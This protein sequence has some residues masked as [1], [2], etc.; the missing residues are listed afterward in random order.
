MSIKIF[1]MTHKQFEAPTDSMY[2]PLQVGHAISPELGYLA[3]DTGD[4]ISR[5]NKSFCELTGIYWL[6]KNYHAC[7]YIGICHYRRYLI[8]RQGLIFTEK[9]LMRL[10]QNHDM[11]TPKLLTLNT[12]Y[13]NGFSQNH[14]QKDLLI[15]E[16]VISEKYPD[17]VPVFHHMVHDVHTYF[18]NIFIFLSSCNA[19]IS[20]FVLFGLIERRHANNV[21]DKF[22]IQLFYAY[23]EWLFDI[24]FEVEC[25][26]DI[27]SYDNYC[28]RLFGFLSEFLLTVYIAK[29]NLSTYECMVGMSG[30][31]HETRMLRESL[32]KCFADG[33]YQKAQSIF[34]ESYAKRP[35]ILMEASDITGELHLCMQ[36]ISTCSFEQELYGHNLL[37]MIHDYHSLMEFCH[38]LNEIVNHFLTVTESAADISWLKKSTALSPKA[39]DIAIQMFCSD[40]DLKEKVFSKICSHLK[41]F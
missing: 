33:D 34:M 20:I 38:R 30:E 19:H 17:Y 21:F 9:E 6:W 8:N 41:D 29:Q 4:N 7:D 13:F 2:V 32:A 3:D 16:Q 40:E 35:D 10:L 26:V 1:V 15:T 24:L 28:K 11:I 18:G 39:V 27:S 36:V 25:R 22:S 12:S 5:K 31:K 23:C 37:D 14:H